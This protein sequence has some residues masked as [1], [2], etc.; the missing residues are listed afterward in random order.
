MSPA[1]SIRNLGKR[2]RVNHAQERASYRTLRDSLASAAA[3]PL[4]QLRGKTRGAREDFWALR[5]VSFDIQPGEV[6]GIIGRNGA[7][8]STLLK[9]LS[10]ITKPSTGEVEING[11]VGSLLE[12][13]TGFHPELTGRENI[14]MNGSILGMS[15][16]EIRR[17]FDEIVEFSEVEKFLDTPVKRYSSGMYVRLAFAVAAHLEPE[18]LVVDEVLAV[19]D[20]AFQKK[21]LGKLEH[22]SQQG[23]TVIIVSHNLSAIE[24]VCQRAVCIRSGSVAA[25]GLPRCVIN[26]YLEDAVSSESGVFDVTSHPARPAHAHVTITR[27]ALSSSDGFG[28]SQFLPHDECNVDITIEPRRPIRCPR[29]AIAIE[30]HH[31]RR[32][33]TAA[34]YFGSQLI[35][36]IV[37]P[38]VARCTIDSLPLA[39]GRYLLSVSVSTRSDGNIDSLDCAAWLDI[40]WSNSYGNGEPYNTVY[41]PI[42][43]DSTWSTAIRR[44][45]PFLAGEQ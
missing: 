38:T 23:R 29:V 9:I 35:S 40:A 12:V 14:Y 6:V 18:V 19:G 32:L 15:R 28:T 20:T 25:D 22:V 8:K 21:C 34:T 39:P 31:G 42:M 17:R 30:D 13:G 7:G 24:A 37:E 27:V 1:I 5:D 43:C 44:A 2:Y 45:H 4:R 3:A 33:F 10:R 26:E 36:D 41:G 16:R 11:R